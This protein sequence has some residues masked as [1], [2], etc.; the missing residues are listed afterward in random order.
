MKIFPLTVESEI[1]VH[2]TALYF[3]LNNW[4][5]QINHSHIFQDSK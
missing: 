4:S 1:K 5:K 3:Y 2:F